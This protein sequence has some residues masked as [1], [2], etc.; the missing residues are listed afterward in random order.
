MLIEKKYKAFVIDQES[1]LTVSDLSFLKSYL[2][3]KSAD[4]MLAF[5]V[6]GSKEQVSLLR[7]ACGNSLISL[8]VDE[9]VKIAE[10]KKLHK[11]VILLEADSKS[12]QAIDRWITYV[13]LD[14]AFKARGEVNFAKNSPSNRFTFFE[15][16]AHPSA[17]VLE[18]AVTGVKDAMHF[19]L[20]KTG[21][22]PNF[23]L[24]ENPA[25]VEEYAKTL[26]LT[27]KVVTFDENHQPIQNVRWYGFPGLKTYGIAYLSS[28]N[29]KYYKNVN[30]YLGKLN[31][32]PVKE[33]YE[34]FPVLFTFNA[35]TYQNLKAFKSTKMP[36][37]QNLLFYLPFRSESLPV[38]LELLN[39]DI[40]I[41]SDAAG[42]YAKFNGKTNNLYFKIPKYIDSITALSISFWL[43]PDAI[44]RNYA[45]LAS[46]DNYVVKIRKG[47]LCLTI[48]GGEDV[49]S[50]KL[51]LQKGEWQH[52]AL[53]ISNG[54]DIKFYKNGTLIETKSI[55][56]FNLKPSAHFL[57]GYDQW[58]EFLEGGLKELAFWNR[59][60]SEA[61]V[62]QVFNSGFV[63]EEKHTALIWMAVVFCLGIGAG[64]YFYVIKRKRKVKS[65]V[66]KAPSIET[67]LATADISFK[68]TVDS[69]LQCFGSFQFVDKEGNELFHQLSL[70][71]K[72]FLFVI[73]YHTI[74]NGG[75]S[76]TD[77]SDIVWPGYSAVSA[78]NVRST[79]LQ[80][81][82]STIPEDYLKVNYSNKLWSIELNSSINCD[83]KEYMKVGLALKTALSTQA[84]PDFPL[85]ES[86]LKIIGNG[87]LAA[88]IHSEIVDKFKSSV[89]VEI[90]DS[91][92][93]ILKHHS[94][95]LSDDLLLAIAGTLHLFDPLHED[96]LI[97]RISKTAVKH[98]GKA[99]IILKQ[100]CSE[101]KLAYG[102]AY[103]IPAEIEDMLK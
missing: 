80:N 76:P 29:I 37:Q 33:G 91:L 79:Y 89:D 67:P 43:K 13:Q 9:L 71:K 92:E 70:K 68:K 84:A 12:P 8:Q 23:I 52:L 21:K 83:L 22:Y 24:T 100:F 81:I 39:K 78:K 46:N 1:T 18:S 72:A 31:A 96:V 51:S 75:I 10:I 32:S 55:R 41:G 82:R 6:T 53:T 90:I 95:V 3:N 17:Q 28:P 94:A 16:D 65:V 4:E 34:F 20:K 48:P 86:Y 47:Y 103:V 45:I 30:R 101:W 49:L 7:T 5:I 44:D 69:H 97:L 93:S 35:R 50:S 54:E 102:T 77:L 26:P 87:P 57:V 38:D 60:L 74:K 66:S 58:E 2:A 59:A 11:R 98:K 40:A 36:I 25:A 14:S 88:N 99:S 56:Y 62:K 19:Y 63:K 61:E 85:I 15:F 42:N 64:L 73:L 27:V